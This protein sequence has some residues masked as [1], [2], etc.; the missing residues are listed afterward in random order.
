MHLV[1]SAHDSSC[2]TRWLSCNEAVSYVKSFCPL[3]GELWPW[4]SAAARSRGAGSRGPGEQAMPPIAPGS[5]GLAQGQDRSV[6]RSQ[7]GALAVVWAR[8]SAQWWT[9]S[10]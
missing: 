4:F 7:S 9:A 1:A 2:I 6:A 8:W 10:L 5:G 3:A